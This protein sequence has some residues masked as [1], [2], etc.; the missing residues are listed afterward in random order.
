[1]TAALFSLIFST[2]VATSPTT[3][4]T[5][6]AWGG[7]ATVTVETLPDQIVAGRAIQLV[8]V[9]KQHGKNPLDGL[10][11]VVEF[12]AGGPVTRVA[13]TAGKSKGQYTASI[14]F[15]NVGSWNVTIHSGF[16]ES[17]LTLNP[18]TVVS[19]ALR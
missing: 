4:P 10:K 18:L 19:I 1:M 13:A 3:A 2:V 5:P 6:T 12:N 14:T 15:P 11:P 8:F 17:K 16:G 7:W 9:V